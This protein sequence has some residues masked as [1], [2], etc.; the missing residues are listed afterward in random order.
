LNTEGNGPLPQRVGPTGAEKWRKAVIDA[1]TAGTRDGPS[2]AFNPCA[3]SDV[4][5]LQMGEPHPSQAIPSSRFTVDL[6]EQLIR[7]TR[8][9]GRCQL[10]IG[11]KTWHARRDAVRVPVKFS[12]HR[13][14]KLVNERVGRALC[15]EVP[16]RCC[17]S[18]VSHPTPAKGRP[19]SSLSHHLALLSP[20][21][22]LKP[23][24]SIRFPPRL[25]SRAL[26]VPGLNLLLPGPGPGVW[27]RRISR[28]L[29]E[30]EVRTGRELS[31]PWYFRNSSFQRR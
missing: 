29:V 20:Q 22:R 25:S 13:R 19:F 18:W 24:G 23:A 2:P 16:P 10:G 5:R 28:G 15:L 9:R 4:A 21:W 6:A 1:I 3:F 31:A 8:N 26:P 27:R 30:P 7:M 12:L 11:I 14:A 17:V